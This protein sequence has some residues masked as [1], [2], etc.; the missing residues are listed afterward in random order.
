MSKLVPT[1]YMQ[2][3]FLEIWVNG[4]GKVHTDGKAISRTTGIVPRGQEYNLLISNLNAPKAISGTV[5][6]VRVLLISMYVPN[7]PKVCS[8]I[9]ETTFGVGHFRTISGHSIANYITKLRFRQSF[10][11]P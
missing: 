4:R 9:K 7:E 3:K 10:C 2:L 11:G 8:E 5:V 1:P 6:F